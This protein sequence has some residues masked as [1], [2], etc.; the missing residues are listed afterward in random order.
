MP[1]RDFQAFVIFLA[2]LPTELRFRDLVGFAVILVFLP[3]HA[4][5][6]IDEGRALI[7]QFLGGRNDARPRHIRHAFNLLV[8][9]GNRIGRN[10]IV[11]TKPESY[12][13]EKCAFHKN[14]VI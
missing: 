14:I 5:I 2:G 11:G 4:A 1:H 10:I 7:E 6:L 13:S 12:L 8:S 9:P 3:Q